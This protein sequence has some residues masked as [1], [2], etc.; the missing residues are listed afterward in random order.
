MAVDNSTHLKRC[1]LCKEEKQLA[2]F[3]THRQKKDGLSSWCKPC[4]VAKVKTYTDSAESRA[5]KKVYDAARTERLQEKLK[6]QARLRYEKK[7]EI[8]LNDVKAWAAAN[9]EKRRAI[10]QGY[11]HRRRAV[12][13]AGISG[14]ELKAWKDAVLK[15]C[16]W[17]GVCCEKGGVVDHYYPLSKGGKHETSNLVLSCRSCNAKKAAKDPLEFAALI[18]KTISTTITPEMT[19]H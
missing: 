10:A 4:S 2:A 16:Y 19:V 13:K 12:E 5:K 18:G 3:S 17:C 8:I 6:Q 15:K 14:A 11:K 9:P 7:R 1:S